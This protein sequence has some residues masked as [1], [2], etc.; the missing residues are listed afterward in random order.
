MKTYMTAPEV[1]RML[2]VGRREA[3]KERRSEQ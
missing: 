2:R 1:A 3:R